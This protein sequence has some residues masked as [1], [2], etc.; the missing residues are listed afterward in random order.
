MHNDVPLA[1]EELISPQQQLEIPAP[2]IYYVVVYAVC[3]IIVESGPLSPAGR[4]AATA[5]LAV[6]VPW[7][8]LVGRRLL[9]ADET[10]WRALS[11]LRGPPTTGEIRGQTGRSP[12][13]PPGAPG[14]HLFFG[15]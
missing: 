14:S 2:E 4:V 13:F 3:V 5:A 12:F 11:A 10:G 15:R 6:M 1:A 7:Y 8:L 9:Y